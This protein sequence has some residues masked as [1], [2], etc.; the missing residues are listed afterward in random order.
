MIETGEKNTSKER[1]S[2]CLFDHVLPTY[3]NYNWLLGIWAEDGAAIGC[4]LEGGMHFSNI[5]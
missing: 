4:R 1:S 5:R 2:I 3:S